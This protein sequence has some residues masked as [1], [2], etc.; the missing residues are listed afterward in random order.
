MTQLMRRPNEYLRTAF[1]FNKVMEAQK[2][3]SNSCPK[4]STK[5]K[6][7][8]PHH[9]KDDSWRH[10]MLVALQSSANPEPIRVACMKANMKGPAHFGEVFHG[11]LSREEVCELL[12]GGNGRYL[13]RESISSPGDHILSFSNG[14]NILH[15][16]LFYDAAEKKY[17]TESDEKQYSSLTDLML[18]I[19]NMLKV[20]NQFSSNRASNGVDKEAPSPR[21][22]KGKRPS[23]TKPHNFKLH[24]Y[25][26][27]KWC[28]VCHS[29]MWGLMRQGMKCHDC[30]LNV[31]KHCVKDVETNCGKVTV[32]HKIK[33][34]PK[35]RRSSRSGGDQVRADELLSALEDHVRCD[36]QLDCLRYLSSEKPPVSK[37]VLVAPM[38]P[39]YCDHC[40]HL[41]DVDTPLCKIGD[42]PH[43]YSLPLGWSR[44]MLNFACED[45]CDKVTTWNIAYYSL[46]PESLSTVLEEGLCEKSD[47]M[48]PDAKTF[49]KLTPSIICADLDSKMVEYQDPDSYEVSVVQM[50]LQ[51]YVKPGSFMTM[52]RAGSSEEIDPYFRSTDIYW[53][54][55]ERNAVIPFGVLVKKMRMMGK[56][57]F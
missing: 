43:A 16:K 38:N 25:M 1:K 8:P 10:D 2:T 6:I 41:K 12:S 37:F 39:C 9:L 15:Y 29:F 32:E 54:V 53:V 11:T 51:V 50:V 34:E 48:F 46:S 14:G 57:K 56:T 49:V 44:F 35:E 45:I 27:P 31:H 40:C 26:H 4:E 47:T 30:N 17:F 42:P 13:I 28:D 24:Q 55:R 36:Y 20:I 5:R 7:S 19:L 3:R 52:G 22:R 23:F 18:D 33:E 21:P